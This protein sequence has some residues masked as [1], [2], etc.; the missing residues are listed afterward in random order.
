LLPPGG[1]SRSIEQLA[2]PLQR[3]TNDAILFVSDAPLRFRR[4]LL[5]I[6]ERISTHAS[7]P[8]VVT[9]GAAAPATLLV[10]WWLLR[11]RTHA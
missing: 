1:F 8:H 3:A 10:I 6:S 9:M 11:R 7:K 4:L 5:A 2:P